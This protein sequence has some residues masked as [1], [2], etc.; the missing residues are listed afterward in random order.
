VE[1]FVDAEPLGELTLRGFHRPI[2]AF[3]LIRLK[4]AESPDG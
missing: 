2:P 4:E 1:A 3:N